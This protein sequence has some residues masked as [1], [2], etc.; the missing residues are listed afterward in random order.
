MYQLSVVQ[1]IQQHVGFF[2]TITDRCHLWPSSGAHL[3]KSGSWWTRKQLKR[4][5]AIRMWARSG[6]HLA[7]SGLW[8]T[9]K[10]LRDIW[11]SECGPGLAY[12]WQNL[13][14]DVQESSYMIFGNQNTGQVWS[15]FGKIWLMITRKQLRDIWQSECGPGQAYI[16]QNLAYDEHECWCWYLAIRI[17]AK[18]GLY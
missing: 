17:W 2:P 10:Q 1:H 16:W 5:L 9:R 14:W 15:S 13:A 12:I 6:L 3:A 11:Q 4:Y 8:W 18:S 7:K